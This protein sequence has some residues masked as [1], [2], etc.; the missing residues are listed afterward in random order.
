MC[1]FIY[2]IV[3]LPLLMHYTLLTGSIDD[4]ALWE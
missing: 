2:F 1:H 3:F 4:D